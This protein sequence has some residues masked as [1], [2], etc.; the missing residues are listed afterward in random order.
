[1]T[2]ILENFT[3]GP[4]KVDHCEH[5]TGFCVKDK[6]GQLV[7]LPCTATRQR[8][9]E[10]LNNAYLI[11]TAPEMYA[12]L[13]DARREFRTLSDDFSLMSEKFSAIKQETADMALYM[14][15]K[16]DAITDLLKKARGIK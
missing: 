13:A 16:A 12:L 4:W 15:A 1:M 10:P 9:G 5:V 14:M 7:A 2:E 6:D 11:A 8:K 3:P